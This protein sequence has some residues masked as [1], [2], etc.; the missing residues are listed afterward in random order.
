M[1]HTRLTLAL[2]TALLLAACGSGDSGSTEPPVTPPVVT[3]PT[4]TGIFIDAP[5][6]GL[7]YTTSGGYTGTT[8]STGA[9]L[10]N[11]GE[12]VTFKIGTLSLGS[13]TGSPAIYPADLARKEGAAASNVATNLMVLLQ[14]LNTT[15][16]TSVITLPASLATATLPALDLKADPAA[17]AALP[18]LTQVMTTAGIKT[19]VVTPAA[20]SAAA[21]TAF[22]TATAGMWQQHSASGTAQPVF[23]RFDG[24]GG[25]LIGNAN[26]TDNKL[27]GV[28][29]GTLQWDPLSNTFKATGITP[30]SNGTS[31]LSHRDTA[32]LAL[33]LRITGSTV[34]ATAADGSTAW[35]LRRVP[36]ATDTIV[37]SW[38]FDASRSDYT[39]LVF[40]ADGTYV[41]LDTAGAND[42]GCKAPAGIELGTFTADRTTGKVTMVSK[43]VDTNGCAGFDVNATFTV[44]ALSATKMTVRWP[45]GS[46]DELFRVQP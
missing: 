27:N 2:C 38:T 17:F 12:T 21:A 36:T 43:K 39:H 28:E 10:Y 44:T 34:T 13:S 8:D 11:T 7:S 42:P 33:T 24:K 41:L 22:H 14:S 23:W 4:Q 35:Q 1:Q 20:A 29:V 19:P 3:K 45:E 15:P 37:G 32:S 31:G 16:G 18:A 6:A 30:D 46:G 26:E 40:L 25:Y 9:F 5:V